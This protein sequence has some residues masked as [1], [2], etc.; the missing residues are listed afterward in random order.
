M[1]AGTHANTDAAPAAKL[2]LT[3][4]GKKF[5][6][7]TGEAIEAVKDVSFSVA[8]NEFCVLLGP[9]G[10]GKSNALRMIAGLETPSSGRFLLDDEPIHGPDRDRGMVLQSYTS[11]DR[12]TV[13]GNI[14]YGMKRNGVPKAER[15]PRAAVQVL[16]QHAGVAARRGLHLRRLADGRR[17]ALPDRVRRRR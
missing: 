2:V 4:V 1:T 13:E 15:A 7:A 5:S 3:G 9:S 14:E 12:L 8:S 16:R 6:V 10:C 17:R 11:F